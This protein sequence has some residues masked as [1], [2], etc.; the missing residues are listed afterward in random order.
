MDNLFPSGD[1]STCLQQYNL[2]KTWCYLPSSLEIAEQFLHPN[3]GTPTTL[4][5]DLS[6]PVSLKLIYIL[7][8]KNIDCIC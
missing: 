3:R 5:Y 6:E 8:N 4:R 7:S 1:P 2:T